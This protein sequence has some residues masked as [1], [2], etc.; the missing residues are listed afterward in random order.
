MWRSTLGENVEVVSKDNAE[1]YVWGEVCDGWH[2]GRLS[3]FSVI[4]E[5]VPAG[6]GEVRHVHRKAEQFLF[7]LSGCVTL[8][9]NGQIQQ[10]L[11]HQGPHIPC[12]TPNR[13]SNNCMEDLWFVLT[14][15]PP[16]HD[17]RVE[18]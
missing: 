4:Q 12:N 17:D 2:L 15:T 7:V 1:N 18:L 14:S 8:E 13:L 9:A 11:Q 10:L 3:T 5:R 16:S 6:C